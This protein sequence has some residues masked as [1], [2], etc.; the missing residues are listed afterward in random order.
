[1]FNFLWKITF[2]LNSNK[3]IDKSDHLL[4]IIKLTHY[5]GFYPN[6]SN[7]KNSYFNLENGDF[8]NIKSENTITKEE[9]DIFKSILNERCDDLNKNAGK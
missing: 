2:D 4:F 5:L 7:I 1:M 3:R 8:E 9:S 6:V